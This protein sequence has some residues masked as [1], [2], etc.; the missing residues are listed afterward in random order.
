M[1]VAC[2]DPD[3]HCLVNLGSEV[4]LSTESSETKKCVEPPTVATSQGKQ[5]VRLTPYNRR[6]WETFTARCVD[7]ESI[8]DV[9]AVTSPLLGPT[10][11]PD[12][13]F[14]HPLYELNAYGNT[15]RTDRR[16]T[17]SR[18][19][20]RSELRPRRCTLPLRDRS[21]LTGGNLLTLNN[22]TG[23]V[24]VVAFPDGTAHGEP[25]HFQGLHHL[26]GRRSREGSREHDHPHNWRPRPEFDN[27]PSPFRETRRSANG[28]HRPPTPP[29]PVYVAVQRVT[30]TRHRLSTLPRLRETRPTDDPVEVMLRVTVLE[31]FHQAKFIDLPTA[32]LRVGVGAWFWQSIWERRKRT[33]WIL[34]CLANLRRAW[35]TVGTNYTVTVIMKSARANDYAALNFTGCSAVPVPTFGLTLLEPW[36]SHVVSF[37]PDAFFDSQS[38]SA[39]SRSAQCNH[40]RRRPNLRHRALASS[41]GSPPSQPM[42]A[43]VNGPS[44]QYLTT[45]HPEIPISP[46]PWLYRPAD[47]NPRYQRLGQPC[48]VRGIATVDPVANVTLI[49]NAATI[50]VPAKFV[51]VPVDPVS[52]KGSA[53]RPN[54]TVQTAVSWGGT[55]LLAFVQPSP[56]TVLDTSSTGQYLTTFIQKTLY[57]Y[58]L[59]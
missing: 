55:F 26:S 1:T 59:T 18:D 7:G 43:Y 44:E 34:K 2:G 46:T 16:H 37:P 15:R 12:P 10:D 58:D 39:S 29:V 49:I 6:M 38:S 27:L 20:R 11:I 41:R 51:T 31:E 47:S 13:S 4:V 22:V 40:P 42:T 17:E 25:L 35:R 48:S 21:F 14:A 53:E 36:N 30:V 57:P 19:C 9:F 50:L 28:D 33:G 24:T 5:R 52:C 54:A 32:R 23:S 45:L 56:V 8:A 3:V